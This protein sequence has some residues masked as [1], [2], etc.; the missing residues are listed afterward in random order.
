MELLKTKIYLDASRTSIAK[1]TFRALEGLH[2]RDYS[3]RFGVLLL[4]CKGVGKTELMIALQSAGVSLF[5][6]ER[7]KAIFISYANATLAKLPSEIIADHLGHE[8]Q[9]RFKKTNVT[10]INLINEFLNEKVIA[11]F[12][13]IDEFQSVYRENCKIGKEIVDEVM[14]IGCLRNSSIFCMIS[15][16]GN[17]LRELTAAKLPTSK[18]IDFPNYAGIDL[19]SKKFRPRW[20]SPFVDP[21]DF[22]NFVQMKAMKMRKKVPENLAELLINTGGV[23]RMI[24]SC[25]FQGH[26]GHFCYGPKGLLDEE[27]DQL[28]KS[29]FR[30]IKEK[31]NFER[32][33]PEELLSLGELVQMVPLHSICK[34]ISPEVIYALA[35]RGLIRFDDTKEVPLIGF[36]SQRAYLNILLES[37]Q[38]DRV[39]NE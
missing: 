22:K 35:D 12:V 1:E 34:G 38:N 13:V 36:G 19:T 39:P 31:C 24:E 32:E 4:G 18:R 16:S 14:E 37:T 9:T 10:P 17:N 2:K 26:P 29:L 28:L 5:W 23:P 25:M 27:S 15:G 7:T 20:V 33:S 3:D 8:Y 11:A 30:C 6:P 21:V